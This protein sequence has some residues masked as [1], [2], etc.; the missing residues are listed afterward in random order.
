MRFWG[1]LRAA[2]GCEGT[3]VDAKQLNILLLGEN[4]S[5]W[6]YPQNQLQSRGCRCAF[7]RSAQEALELNGPLDYDLILTRVT[8]AQIDSCLT[9]LGGFQPNVS[10]A[11]RWKMA[12]GG[13]QL[14]GT[15]PSASAHPGFEARNSWGFWIRSS[16]TG[17][18]RRSRP[19]SRR[20]RPRLPRASSRRAGRGVRRRK[21]GTGYSF[22]ACRFSAS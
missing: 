1:E 9:G 8:V 21:S 7:A 17:S 15:G 13:C 2:I 19:V 5:G 22:A 11:I 3:A 14:F 6:V 18:R 4:Q 10:T 16:E 12:A 20:P